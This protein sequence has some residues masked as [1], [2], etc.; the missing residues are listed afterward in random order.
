MAV[1][2]IVD[3]QKEYVA[4]GRPFY[5]ETIDP[6]LEN[7]RR[8]LDFARE[9]GWKVA[10][11][12]H[13]QNSEC[14]TWGSPFSEFIEGFGPENGELEFIKSN[15][16]CFS[17]A[18]FKAFMDK[19]RHEEIVL[20]GFG[21]SMCC[22][23]TLVDGH[24]RGIEFTFAK[25]ATCARRTARYGEQDMKEHIIDIANAFCRLASTDEIMDKHK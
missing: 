21:T 14:F 7:L 25:D 19:Y 9:K 2:V 12:R 4:K 13:M 5:L 24:H 15:F 16:S 23:S 22:L 6:A 3:A 18:E 1:L 8:L 11:V 10:H 20:A 17:S